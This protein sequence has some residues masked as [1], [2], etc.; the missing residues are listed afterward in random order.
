MSN[1]KNPATPVINI[2]IALKI[3]LFV[4]LEKHIPPIIASNIFKT[5]A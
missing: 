5:K 3:R 1:A 2:Y 4:I